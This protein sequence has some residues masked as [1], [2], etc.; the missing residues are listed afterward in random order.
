MSR[1]D[2]RCRAKRR[3]A[4]QAQPA[5]AADREPAEWACLSPVREVQEGIAGLWTRVVVAWLWAADWRQ[6][7]SRPAEWWFS[8]AM[9]LVTLA[10]TVFTGYAAFHSAPSAAKISFK[11]GVKEDS[12]G[13]RSFATPEAG[14]TLWVGLELTPY[15]QNL[16]GVSVTIA[17]PPRVELTDRCN[18]TVGD[19]ARQ[20]CAMPNGE[21]RIDLAHLDS[22]ETL[23]LSVEARVG[24]RI[25]DRESITIEMS[26]A[27]AEASRRKIDLYSSQVHGATAPASGVAGA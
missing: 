12:G 6:Q 19:S 18:Y 15:H 16:D 10:G 23:R 14:D 13:L 26:A 17:A 25:K 21:G 20:S 7:H 11:T 9:L 8:T 5:T 24:Q 27:E 2:R 3:K 22:G 4:A 1:R